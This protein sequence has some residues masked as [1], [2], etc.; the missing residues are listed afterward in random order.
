M[1]PFTLYS[2]LPSC[3]TA[4]GCALLLWGL[5]GCSSEVALPTP[6]H[7]SVYQSSDLEPGRLVG[8]ASSAGR[9]TTGERAPASPLG[10]PQGLGI[11]LPALTQITGDSLRR[12]ADDTDEL[13]AE[14][15]LSAE[16]T[17]AAPFPDRTNPF[18]FAAGVDFDAPQA[19]AA[20]AQS[21]KLYG[22]IG[23][24][25]PKAILSVGGRTKT[26]ATG[27]K[28]GVLEILEVS[29]P[30]VRIKT[31]GVIRVWSLLGHHEDSM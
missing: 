10:L 15:S 17:P 14:E 27:E 3:C 12:A 22:F 5:A 28:W 11:D 4:G 7:T 29:P 19:K 16:V 25:S 21:V 26:L 20:E 13:P 1:K 2:A 6:E 8:K 23:V 31:N 24:D 18:E 30:T 9:I